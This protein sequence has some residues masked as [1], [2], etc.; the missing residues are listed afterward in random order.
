MSPTLFDIIVD[1]S[2]R[3]WYRLRGEMENILIFYTDDGWLAG[4][5]AS[6]AQRGIDVL[7]D[8]LLR[9][10]VDVFQPGA[11]YVAGAEKWL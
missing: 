3:E 2:I 7:Q 6:D 4:Y 1:C 11:I 10:G 8:L 9:L 5:S